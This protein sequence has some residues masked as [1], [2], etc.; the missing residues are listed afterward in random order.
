MSFIWPTLLLI[1][2]CVPLLV[3]L[4]WRLQQRRS[5]FAAKYGSLGIVHDAK[6]SIPGLRRHLP[7]ALFLAGITIL[8]VSLARLR[9]RSVCQKSKVRSS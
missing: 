4:Y 1:L 6:G 3:L 5:R 2:L 9:R 7:A 8:F